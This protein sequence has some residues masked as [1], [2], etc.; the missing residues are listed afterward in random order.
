MTTKINQGIIESFLNC[1]YKGH[2]KLVGECGI[3]SDYEAMTVAA[4]AASREATLVK[5]VARS[6]E[7]NACRGMSITDATLWKGTPLLVDADF[8]DDDLTLRFDGLKRADGTSKLGEHHYQP[9]LH[10]FGDKVG[11]HQ[12][13]L[14]AM[15]GLA[16]ARVQILRP[17]VGLVARGTEGR[18]GKVRLDA[19]LYKRSEQVLDEVK[20]LQAEG[21][22]PQLVLNDHCQMCEFRRG[23]RAQAVKEDSLSLLRGL[24]EKEI[25]GYARKGIFTLTQLAHTFRPRRRNKR[26]VQQTKRH[27]ALQA[28]AV[29][30]KR[31]YVFGT[32]ELPTSPVT[33]YLD[34]EGLPDEGF[35]YLIGMIVV[36]GGT[37][38]QHSFWADT[39]EQEQEMFERFLAETSRY[40][41]FVVFSYGGY[42]R[43]FLKRMK[44]AA[45]RSEQVDRILDALVNL[46]SVIY[47]HLYFPCHSN[48][49]K[50]VAGCLDCSWSEAEASGLQSIAWRKWWEAS[51]SE[52]WK[53]RLTTYNMED[54]AALKK[55]VMF[56]RHVVDLDRQKD[57]E[58]SGSG[59]CL[60]VGRA[61]E[62]RGPSGRPEWHNITAALPDFDH[63]RK[64]GY[65]DYQ[66]E[67][68]YFHT[69]KT[70]RK[71]C[72]R[73]VKGKTRK[74]PP[75][76]TLE[77]R[78][79]T[80]PGCNSSNILRLSGS[81]KIKVGYDL[82]FSLSGIRRQIIHCTAMIHRCRECRKEFHPEKYKRRDKHL[83][84]LKCWAMYQH[85][86]QRISLHNLQDMFEEFFGLR[87]VEEE[88][89]MIKSLMA[90]RY[91]PTWEK[92]RDRILSGG[93]IHVD[94]TPINLRNGKGYVWVLANMEE[95]IYLYQPT[96]EADFLHEL[97]KPFSGVLVSD[98]FSAYDS[99]PCKQQRCLIHLVRDF[100][101]DVLKNPY[102]DELKSLG[103]E[104]GQ[105]LRLIIS[106][107]D[108]YGLKKRH[109]GKHGD[110]VRRFFRIL[111]SRQYHSE[112]AEGYQTRLIKNESRLFTFLEHDGVPW[113]N[114]NAECAVKR[115]ACYRRISD[116][117][118]LEAGLKDYLV[119]LSIF[120]TCKYKGISFL[121]FLLSREVDVGTYCEQ[122]RKR[123]DPPAIEIYPD[124]FSRTH[125]KMKRDERIKDGER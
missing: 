83:H 34:M 11:R 86:A 120:Q 74:L 107:V 87:I 103:S 62:Q 45:S 5:L 117:Q 20:R 121:K 32:P 90:N 91:M 102:D 109:L 39:K 105:L 4:R 119:L 69:N 106:T 96:R 93:V 51:Q 30:D 118:I 78:Q 42:E 28:M 52:G 95:V 8:D 71:A 10:Q 60:P 29:R 44:K 112:F 97:L 57:L 22:P 43:T 77:I 48:G 23:C 81:A 55:V 115:F 98:F 88:L 25:R 40:G 72:V 76:R 123:I 75:T 2:L 84:G 46:L 54:C 82:R 58:L 36:H 15:F 50:D 101:T 12:K 47:A 73:R 18:L 33:I 64:C 56:V 19:K 14:L 111:A 17:S 125:R 66:R 26:S 61:E 9:I 31:V 6:G 80:C 100:N 38:T 116:G 13:L 99:L 16:I 53:G 124:G 94:E 1:K 92:I 59:D 108:R 49:L 113:N 67:K 37:E 7:G 114:N 68:V 3:K 110:D 85:V 21:E 70:I 24:G 35:V 27:H 122:R 65:F 89:L 41:D 104:F 79:E 63:I